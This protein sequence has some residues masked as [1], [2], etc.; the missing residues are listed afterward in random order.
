M[1]PSPLLELPSPLLEAAFNQSPAPMLMLGPT[2]EAV[3]VAVSDALLARVGR[4]REQ[5]VG[6]TLF[7]AFPANPED[8]DDN[9]VAA[10]HDSL[11][12][13]RESGRAHALVAQR[14]PVEVRTDDGQMRY[15]ERFWDA[16][17]APVFDETGKLLCIL[18][19][20]TD[21]TAR[22]SA[23][24]ALQ[25]CAIEARVAAERAESQR[26]RLDA[27]LNA[28]P[29]GIVVSDARG[30][31]RRTNR[32]HHRLWGHP[33]PAVRSVDDFA[34]WTGHWADGG[35]R[36]G[37]RLEA[38]E[39]PTARVLRG[40][41]ASH[42]IIRIRRFDDPETSRVCL[43]SAAPVTDDQGRRVGAV[44]AEMDITEQVRAENELREADRRK[45][46]FL[47]M[48]AHE[49]RNP[50]A[51][52]GAA[53]DL[54]ALGSAD[55]EHV[56]QTSAIIARQVRHMTGLVD[57]L[58]DVSRVTRGLV[59]L[60]KSR[61]DAKRIIAEAVEQVRPLIEQR[62]HRMTIRLLADPAIVFGDSK[63]LVQVVAN[64]LTNAA[65]YTPE[66]GE[67]GI[68]L[69]SEDDRLQIAVTDTGIGM[70][71]ELVDRVFDLFSQAERT[72]DRSQGGLG[73][74][75]ALVRRLLELHDGTISAS[76]PGPGHGSRF[77]IC[78][79][80]LDPAGAELADGAAPLLPPET[81]QGLSV[82]VV[83]DNDDA[84]QVLAMFVEMIGHHATVEHNSRDALA[85][86]K[87]ERPQVCLLDIGLPDI[88]GIE[89]ARRLRASPET[90]DATLIAITGYGRDQ[91]RAD[92]LEAGF[93]HHFVK[94]VD[95][96]R[97]A[98]VLQ[99]ASH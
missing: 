88:D 86:A 35:P 29:V 70:A 47:A 4:S 5:L 64:L 39:W 82:L 68:E 59:R 12:R 77:T 73:I 53:A 44:L 65:K 19:S 8:E 41:D 56:R 11:A 84:A 99:R 49:L 66:R 26:R 71:P 85:R 87:R 20:S 1:L 30:G 33:Q 55:P 7:E 14:Y 57:D 95:T 62:G 54:L 13:V 21:V 80:R 24:R 43:M 50:L 2:S 67:I 94:P 25:G 81:G 38:Q 90:A 74:G 18:H 34:D 52:I 40:E 23:E 97:L 27:V 15:E 36:S 61:L 10:L 93:D 76:S 83:D 45:D 32:A 89:L 6:R 79:P 51:P 16:V 48:L 17:N 37:Q 96:A 60:E 92:A 28:A 91:D 69:S 78:L 31:V 63:R 22:V 58:L 42:D 98:D 72:S 9:G 3:I 46:E 75:L